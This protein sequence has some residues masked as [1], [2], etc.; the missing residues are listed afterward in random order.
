MLTSN[1]VRLTADCRGKIRGATLPAPITFSSDFLMHPRWR[2]FNGDS[3]PSTPG[4]S[5]EGGYPL[6]SIPSSPG[7][8]S[9]SA[10]AAHPSGLDFPPRMRGVYPASVNARLDAS[11]PQMHVPGAQI[12]SARLRARTMPLQLFAEDVDLLSTSDWAATGDSPEHAGLRRVH[13][14]HG[15]LRQLPDH[16]SHMGPP[17]AAEAPAGHNVLRRAASSFNALQSLPPLRVLPP[18]VTAGS[19][20]LPHVDLDVDFETEIRPYLG[21]CLVCSRIGSLCPCPYLWLKNVFGVCLG[22]APN[23]YGNVCLRLY[24]ASCERCMSRD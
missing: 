3:L 11:A 16:V 14:W 15:V 10:S 17:V 20:P 21:Q 24:D 12:V 18:P 22:P 19:P 2:H 6:F 23:G 9:G 7:E 13:T 8:S 1:Q 5:P 4:F